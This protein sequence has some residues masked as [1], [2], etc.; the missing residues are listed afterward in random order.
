MMLSTA[1]FIFAA[2]LL[3]YLVKGLIGFGNPLISAPILSMGLDN[4][5]ITPGTLLLD[6]PVNAWITWK[7]RRSFQWRKILPLLAV[8][9]CGIIPGT[10]LLRFSMPWVIKTVLGVIVVFLGLEM[11]TRNLRSIRPEREDR[12][13]LRLVVSAFSGVSAGLFGINL[14]IVAYLQ[15]TARDYDEFKGSMCFLFF[16]ENAVRLVVYAVTGLLTRQVL[17][18][19]LASLPA[20]VLALAL[21]AWLGPRLEEGK[22]QKGAI[23]LF[24]LGGVSIIVKS[25]VFHT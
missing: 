10:L 3:A 1:L 18:F 20:A 9:L 11:A 14:F 19:G 8:N 12:P 4:V 24:L 6:C 15:R 25:V 5:V 21:A 23:V 16:G 13:W 17:L 2:Q 7:N 22:L